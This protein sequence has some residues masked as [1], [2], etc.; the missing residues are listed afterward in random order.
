MSNPLDEVL[1][2]RKRAFNFLGAGFKEMAG[3]S[4]QEGAA[5]AVGQGAVGL[6]ATGV[7]VAA[8]KTYRAIRKRSDFKNMMQLNPDLSE[9]HESDPTKFNAHYNSMRALVP[10]YAEDPIISG[11][12]MRQ[13]G[14]HPI[15]AGSTL[16]DAMERSSKGRPNQSQ[17]TLSS[18]M[19]PERGQET[20]SSYRF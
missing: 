4:M 11:A 3:R 6:A 7:G 14:E 19:N 2:M 13:M 16:M 20:G 5:Q 12:L 9:H 1:G 18:K 15:G 17:F 10:Q 8:L